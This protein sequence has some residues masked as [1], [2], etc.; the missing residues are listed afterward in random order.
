M[1]GGWRGAPAAHATGMQAK[2]EQDC[3]QVLHCSLQQA[4]LLASAKLGRLYAPMVVV[5]EP[6]MPPRSQVCVLQVGSPYL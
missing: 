1:Q 2:Y 4:L 3:L 6:S 5:V